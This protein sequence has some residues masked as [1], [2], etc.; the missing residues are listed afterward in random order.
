MIALVVEENM[1]KVLKQIQSIW[2][3]QGMKVS[4]L[5][6]LHNVKYDKTSSIRSLVKM[7]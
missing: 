1:N 5:A 6:V 4:P 7:E 2:K 3:R